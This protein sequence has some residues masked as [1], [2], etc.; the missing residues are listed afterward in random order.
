[1]SMADYSPK[2]SKGRATTASPKIAPV[3]TLLCSGVP[4]RKHRLTNRSE[5]GRLVT[6]CEGCGETWESLDAGVRA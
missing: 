5:D 6:Y 1:M 4:G 3:E 2:S